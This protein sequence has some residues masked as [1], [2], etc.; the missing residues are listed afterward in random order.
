MRKGH[1]HI[2][3]NNGCIVVANK[4][5]ISHGVYRQYYHI[6]CN[7]EKPLLYGRT[8]LP[9]L[10]NTEAIFNTKKYNFFAR[11]IDSLGHVIWPGN[12]ERAIHTTDAI[13]HSKS[14]CSSTELKS[15]LGLCNV[16]R[17][18]VFNF[19]H[20]AA[21]LNGSS[22]MESQW[23]STHLGKDGAKIL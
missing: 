1:W 7:A 14:P 11:K 8:V 6:S 22:K 9:I 5:A 20:I 19:F 10:D 21:L 18:F 16:Y 4:M 3:K 23:H 2:S 15:F 13:R 12:M 17:R